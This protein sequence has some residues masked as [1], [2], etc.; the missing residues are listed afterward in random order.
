M[1]VAGLPLIVG[2]VAA[3]ASGEDSDEARSSAQSA[4]CRGHTAAMEKMDIMTTPC[5]N[6]IWIARGGKHT[7]C[8][9]SA[10]RAARIV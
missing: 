5:R 1:L 10:S 3:L 2:A 6:P 4:A 7:G 8:V 9:S